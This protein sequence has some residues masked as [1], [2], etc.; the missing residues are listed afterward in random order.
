MEDLDIQLVQL[1]AMPVVSALGYGADPEYQ[2]WN[3]ILRFA[4]DRQMDPWDSTHRFFGFNNPDPDCPGEQ[5]G[6]E[7]WMTVPEGT[8]AEPPLESKVAAGGLYATLAIHGLDAIGE[9]WQHLAEWCADNGYEM[10]STREACLEELLT[11]L[12]QRPS[13]WDMRLYLAIT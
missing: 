8:E 11:P 7:Q 5:Y 2:A 9:A 6:Y 13:D 10:D 1:A 3:S 4:E 12:D